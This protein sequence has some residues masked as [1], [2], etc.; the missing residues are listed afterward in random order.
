[1]FTGGSAIKKKRITD[2]VSGLIHIKKNQFMVAE[3][4]L[5]FCEKLQWKIWNSP[6]GFPMQTCSQL[7]QHNRQHNNYHPIIGM[8]NLHINIA[9]SLNVLLRHN[10]ILRMFS[11]LT[12]WNIWWHSYSQKYF[13]WLMWANVLTLPSWEQEAVTVTP[14][15]V[16][17]VTNYSQLMTTQ[18]K[19]NK[20]SRAFIPLSHPISDWTRCPVR[21]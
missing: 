7:Q 21:H 6:A 19:D 13:L 4:P 9:A 18:R 2:I 3:I 11:I 12:P 17:V 8:D 15:C 10:N 5:L 20:L 16:C 14:V 1:M